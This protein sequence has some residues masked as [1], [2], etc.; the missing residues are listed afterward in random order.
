MKN[1]PTIQTEQ[2]QMRLTPVLKDAI[3]A[4]AVEHNATRTEVLRMSVE[5]FLYG[6]HCKMTQKEFFELALEGK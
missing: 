5:Q 2:I 1:K 6:R 3:D 4:Y